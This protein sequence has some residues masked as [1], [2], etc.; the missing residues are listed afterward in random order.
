M[1]QIIE[2]INGMSS[3]KQNEFYKA[4]EAKGLS[5]KEINAIKGVAFYT[6]LFTDP[7]AYKAV[8]SGIC[9]QIMGA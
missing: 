8:Q 1:D 6:K 7:A 9:S 5:K 4:L 2:A 3:E